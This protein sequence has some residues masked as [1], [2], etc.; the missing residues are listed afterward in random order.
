[1]ANLTPAIFFGHGS[2]M[3][4]LSR[5][6]YTQGWQQIGR[7]IQKP[8]AVLCIS[9]HYYV[10]NTE[11]VVSTSPQTIH[12][13]GG[14][15]Q[16][17]FDVQYP[18]PGDPELARRVAGMLA[19]LHVEL[20]D[21]WGYDH[22]TWSVLRH[23]FPNADVPVVALSV[24]L[25]RPASYHFE[26]GE[27]LAALREEGVMI[28]GS[29]NLVHNLARWVRDAPDFEPF[30]WARIFDERVKELIQGRDFSEV[31]A[32]ERLGRAAE[33][34]VPTPDHYLPILYVLG[35]SVA[36]DALSFPIEGIDG[37]AMSMRVVQ[38]S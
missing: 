2:P 22:G 19:P 37:G 34:A 1:M 5:N 14:F 23:V 24:D 3:L 12:D 17:L 30:S 20:T 18:A 38:F 31:V 6:R 33:L 9:A 10:P 25:R 29:G 15:P 35:S 13:F 4:T 8:K 7:N 28:V 27:R 21:R 36:Q 32:Y 26:I 16:E 11:I